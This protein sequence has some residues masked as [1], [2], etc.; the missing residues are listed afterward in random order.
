MRITESS[1][2]CGIQQIHALPTNAS[3]FL[4]AINTRK[5]GYGKVLELRAQDLR[6]MYIFSDVIGKGKKSSPGQNLAKFLKK[7]KLGNVTKS[8]DVKNTSGNTIAMWTWIPNVKTVLKMVNT[9]DNIDC[10]CDE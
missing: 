5:D 6:P 2:S 9:F 10:E 7:H 4:S 3:G 1:I 8:A